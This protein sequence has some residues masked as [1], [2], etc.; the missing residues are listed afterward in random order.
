LTH[1]SARFP[2]LTLSDNAHKLFDWIKV[3][4]RLLAALFRQPVRLFGDAPF[5]LASPAQPF[6]GEDTK[7]SKL[8]G[9]AEVSDNPRFSGTLIL[10]ALV[11]GSAD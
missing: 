9:S 5:R 10:S 8:S 2:R 11:N 4:R 7:V 6:G 3:G 1:T